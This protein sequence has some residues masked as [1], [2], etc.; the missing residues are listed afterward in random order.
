M[1]IF[2]ERAKLLESP[3]KDIFAQRAKLLDSETEDF[4]SSF[5]VESAKDGAGFVEAFTRN[6]HKFIPVFGSLID[7]ENYVSAVAAAKRL[8]END[9][10]EA[11]YWGA[12]ESPEKWTRL[13]AAGAW[14][15]GGVGA[16]SWTPERQREADLDRLVKFQNDLIDKQDV[17]NWGKVGAIVGE[18]PAFAAEFLMSGGAAALGKAG[19]KKLTKDALKKT[20]ARKLTAK[21]A[22]K[23][24]GLKAL[25]TAAGATTRL[26]MLAHRVVSS[27]AARQLPDIQI[28][29]NEMSVTLSEEKP[30]MSFMKAIGDV[31][32]EAFSEDLGAAVETPVGSKIL[33]K[34]FKRWAIK[35]PKMDFAKFVSKISTKAGF[36][37]VLQELGEEGVGSAL[38]AVANIDDFGAGEDAGTIERLQAAANVMYKDFWVMSA[39]FAVPGVARAG[40]ATAGSL[41][42]STLPE[43]FDTATFTTREEARQTLE[44]KQQIAATQDVVDSVIDTPSEVAAREASELEN[45]LP[46]EEITPATDHI[47]VPEAEQIERDSFFMERMWGE[48]R[49]FITNSPLL[50]TPQEFRTALVNQHIA[51]YQKFNAAKPGG[52]IQ[53]Q[54]A[55]DI[56][57]V[58]RAVNLLDR[59]QDP[60]E[61]RPFVP[62]EFE[63]AQRPSPSVLGQL[64]E[65]EKRTKERVEAVE[66][67]EHEAREKRIAEE[68]AYNWWKAWRERKPHYRVR[69]VLG[70]VTK[71]IYNT[72]QQLSKEKEQPV[73]QSINE[74]K[75]RTNST[76]FEVPNESPRLPS[77]RQLL[78]EQMGKRNA[79]LL[80]IAAGSKE[81]YNEAI[82][83]LES[84]GGLSDDKDIAKLQLNNLRAM[85][86]FRAKL[87]SKRE[88]NPK[89]SFLQKFENV[90]Y[91]LAAFEMSSGIPMRALYR[92]MRINSNFAESQVNELMDNLFKSIGLSARNH[93]ITIEQNNDMAQW[94]Y[95][96]NEESFNRLPNELQALARG[97]DELLQTVGRT[98]VT[99]VRWK[100]WKHRGKIPEALKGDKK[101]QERIFEEGLAAEQEGKLEEWLAEQEWG[102]KDIY[103][104]TET[105]GASLIDSIL[106]PGTLETGST[107]RPGIIPG[108][109]KARKAKGKAKLGPVANNVHNHL[110][111]LA[112]TDILFED[113]I[114]FWDGFEAAQPSSKDVRDMKRFMRH[115]LGM[116]VASEAF[117]E[118]AAKTNRVFWWSY[119]A[120]P[121][122]G[123]TFAVRNLHQNL[124][125]L[126]TQLSPF[127]ALKAV[128]VLS[129]EAK[130]RNFDQERMADFH[131]QWET[132]IRQQSKLLHEAILLEEEST[133][134][135][136]VGTDV[137]AFARK[138]SE[139]IGHYSLGSDS[140]NRALAW[141]TFY[142]STKQNLKDFDSGKIDFNELQK[143][144]K[145]RV[146]TESQQNEILSLID[147]KQY[148]DAANLISSF[149]TENVHGRYET[150]ERA[151]AEQTLSGR[152]IGGLTVFPRIVVNLAYRN[153]TIPLV[154]GLKVGDYEQAWQGL[155]SILSLIIGSAIARMLYRKFTGKDAY[156]IPTYSPISP[157]LSIVA[158]TFTDMGWAL[159][160]K[161]VKAAVIAGASNLEIA[162]P[163]AH[164]AINMYEA[165]EN[166]EGVRLWQM[167]LIGLKEEY[168]I[169]Y[170]KHW[171]KKSWSNWEKI[172]HSLFGGDWD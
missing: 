18:M 21:T 127:E 92:K 6:P 121:L 132:D 35:H 45:S 150:K 97:L 152:A 27:Y 137:K 133:L 144:L 77:H 147:K 88:K 87:K 33:K 90:R 82:D 70:R 157:G 4:F 53:K 10:E 74:L 158:K 25:E 13:R 65:A 24:T 31:W 100:L 85:A 99:S 128:R 46:K 41:Y 165:R 1:G 134:Y 32:I 52:A 170:K 47:E 161:G 15:I 151:A 131:S 43:A 14:T 116:P 23:I 143:R 107:P 110:R 109:A 102:A 69:G 93:A 16:P 26:P 117:G 48:A 105:E 86:S 94:L 22:A 101:E 155:T 113:M 125:Y 58:I 160:D 153:G 120:D 119:F 106:A 56:Y 115:L 118:A 40:I 129:S 20:L 162:I 67:V 8:E 57:N 64:V 59:V 166:K 148:R 135:K 163:L 80:R 36:N 114:M 130:N 84:T 154:R 78:R 126:W 138:W 89:Y 164:T 171:T 28:S 76:D 51:L 49:R 168:K 37:G 7:A 108:A 123:L 17:T 12:V 62:A 95:D 122:R 2:E 149:K 104:M 124:A 142:I 55:N 50:P 3:A 63:E 73:S 83:Y 5:A 146:L 54:A 167:I 103:Y 79:A 98:R 39:A 9:Y 44:Q 60:I 75:A 91:A 156:G 11:P 145:L 111:R 38:R 42:Q 139:T 30:Y 169:K 29:N 159:Q 19:A 81:G 96:R 66:Q 68:N 112:T 172:G 71:P 136:N 141:H 61:G 140:V 72:A 34:L